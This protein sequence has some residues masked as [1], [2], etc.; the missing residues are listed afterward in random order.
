MCVKQEGEKFVKKIGGVFA[1]KVTNGPDG[2]QATWVVDVKNGS[3]CVHNDTGLNISD[4]ID[5]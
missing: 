3:G 1:F 5:I 2:Q 4:F